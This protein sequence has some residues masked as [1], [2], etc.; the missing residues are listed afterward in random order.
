MLF[1]DVE[2]LDDAL[3]GYAWS[4]V[5]LALALSTANYALRFLKW[6]LCLGWLG[7]RQEGPGN[8]PEL[9]RGRSALIYAGGLSMSVTPGKVGEVLRSVLLRSS[10][11]VSGSRTAPIVVADRLTDLVA[12]VLLSL[13]GIARFR[14]YLPVVVVTA[15]LVVGALLVLG[16][17]RLLHAVLPAVGRLGLH[18][19]TERLEKAID[20]SAVLLR[21]RALLLLSA[22]SV[23]GWGME[24]VGYYVVLRGFAGVEPDLAVSAFLWATTTLIGAVSFLPG[25]LGATEGSLAVLATRLV[26]GVTAPIAVASTLLIRAATLWFALLIG[27]AALAVFLRDPAIRRASAEAELLTDS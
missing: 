6:E 22:I 1:V 18:S 3:E 19:L 13:I 21:P 16:S 11:G 2:R 5:A 14:E 23:V 9:T 27:G 10:D 24:C 8:A 25:G 20:S 12:L 26:P 17:P 7:V 15:A 4:A